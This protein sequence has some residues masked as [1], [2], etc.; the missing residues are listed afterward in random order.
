MFHP[1]LSFL[2]ALAAGLAA[3]GFSATV[4]QEITGVAPAFV[5]PYVRRSRLA[6]SLAT[7]AL[8]GPYMLFNEALAAHAENRV[9]G[10]IVVTSAAVALGWALAA[11][12]VLVFLA[13]E[14][15]SLLQS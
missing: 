6:T 3:G 13:G 11:G 8:L 9:S 10:Q 4:A 15:A 2:F 12:I 1:A 14:F 7:T 5:P